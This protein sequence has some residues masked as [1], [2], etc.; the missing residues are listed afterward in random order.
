M[1]CLRVFSVI[2]TFT[3][4][5]SVTSAI[6]N[7]QGNPRPLA[8]GVLET[9]PID[10]NPRDM[11][12]LPMMMPGMQATEYVPKTHPAEAT[13][14]GQGH[15]VIL[16]RDNVWE[17]EFSFIGLRQARV[18]VPDAKGQLINKN[19]WYL[20]YRIRNTGKTMTYAKVK[21]NPEFDHIK[22]DLRYDQLVA[23]EKINFRPQFTLTGWVEGRGKYQKVE[24][25]S[26]VNPVAA[27]RIRQLEDPNQ[28]L[29][30][31]EQMVEA[32]IPMAKNDADPGVW[33][34]AIW[35]DVNP[36]L[37]F[38]SVYVQG[39]SNAY[40]L[41]RQQ[42]NQPSKLKTLQLN[43]WRPGD[44]VAEKR[45]DVE[46]GIPLVDKPEEQI[47]ICKRYALPGPVIHVYEEDK[48][49]EKEVLVGE[50][51]ADIDF[52]TLQSRITPLMDMGKLPPEVVAALARS[53]VKVDQNAAVTTVTDGDKWRFS[54]GGR[55]FVVQVKPMFWEPLFGKIRFINT[56]EHLWIYR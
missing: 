55:S 11:H 38:V 29:L 33:G 9:I 20:V 53:G 32:E 28:V 44:V 35:E 31:T 39:L 12:S 50:V 7:A 1:H 43:F 54:D 23:A 36:R 56:L 22:H 16:Y 27:Y 13:L 5:L 48:L 19:F 8:P 18:R 41:N 15:R 37:D 2:L 42:P 10:L 40:R 17:Y 30:D 46:F 51:D 24:Y 6:V 14:Y 49:A 25:P 21:Q 26:V 4:C 45:D 3:L 34:V 47:E 52:D